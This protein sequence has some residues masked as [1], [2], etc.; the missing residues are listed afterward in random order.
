MPLIWVDGIL[1][2]L[3]NKKDKFKG[4]IRAEESRQ[5][6]VRGALAPFGA[7]QKRAAVN[8]IA[9]LKSQDVFERALEEIVNAHFEISGWTLPQ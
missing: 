9:L 2:A 6:L 3:G 4:V 7:D 1:R 5:A 8:L